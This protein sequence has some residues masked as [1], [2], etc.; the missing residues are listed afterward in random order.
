MI[1][2]YRWNLVL[3]T[4]GFA[5]TFILSIEYN[6]FWRTLMSSVY[7]FFIIFVAA[8]ALRW[9]LGTLI[10]LKPQPVSDS[11]QPM[12]SQLP[13][14]PVGQTVDTATPDDQDQLNEM[15]KEQL[16][17]S[18]SEPFVPLQPKKLATVQE[19]EAQELAQAVRH[20]TEK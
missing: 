11:G 7:S 3:G 5:L 20:L 1:G 19:T 14:E 15:L 8:F 17:R 6:F 13:D 16:N 4:L 9:I 2:S 12:E 18:D 10:G